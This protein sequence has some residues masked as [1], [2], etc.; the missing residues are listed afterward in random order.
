MTSRETALKYKPPGP[1]AKSFLKSSAMVKGLRG[2]FGSGKST[3]CVFGLT[4]NMQEQ[5]PGPDGMVRRRTVI[6]RNTYGELKTTTGKTW[7]QWYPENQGHK[8]NASPPTHLLTG[9]I[10]GKKFQWE[11][12][13]LALDRPEDVAKV[14]SLELSDAW[15]NEAREVP[16]AVVEGI[17]GRIGRYPSALQGGC[18]RPQLLM[19]TNS[20]DSDHWWYKMAEGA[21]A[22]TVQRTKDL[23]DQ[24]RALGSLKDGQR[25]YEFFSQ[26]S[27]LSPEAENLQWLEQDAESLKLP[28]EQRRDRGR[29]Y[30]LKL[31]AEKRQEWI[32]VYIHSNYGFVM[33]GRP[34]Y[35]EYNDGI[36][37][38]EFNVSKLIG[39]EIGMDFGLTPAAVFGQRRQNGQWLKHSEIVT[40][41]MGIPAFANEITKRLGQMYAGFPLLSITGDPAGRAANDDMRTTYDILKANGVHAKEAP[42]NVLTLRLESVRAPMTRM[43]DGQPGMLVHPQ[44]ATLRKGYMGGYFYKRVAVSGTDRYHDEP[45]KGNFSHVCDADQYLMLGGGEGKIIVRADPNLRGERPKFAIS[46]ITF[47]I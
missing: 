22:D 25:L 13:F 15:I 7:H 24:L 34:V 6:V 40:T 12:I 3:A 36:H 21:D 17:T 47:D 45:D 37:C 35:P 23:E 44:A 43:I 16:L 46:D 32:N 30:Y 31:A 14:L 26:P 28:E 39:I 18:A 38:K 9:A 2:P 33:D 42:S 8:S 41:R 1:I 27:G 20:M 19:D 5:W 29:A 10:S 11:I 4:L